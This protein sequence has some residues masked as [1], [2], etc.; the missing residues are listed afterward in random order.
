VVA[1]P[2][3]PRYRAAVLGE[4]ALP[5]SNLHEHQTKRRKRPSAGTYRS[6]TGRAAGTATQLS[7][8]L[9]PKVLITHHYD[10]VLGVE[11]LRNYLKKH[12]L[13]D[14]HGSDYLFHLILDAT[15]DHYAPLLDHFDDSLDAL[16]AQVLAQPAKQQLL[17]LLGIKRE[18]VAFRKTLIH[19]RE[20]L[21]RMA[22]GEFAL[23]SQREMAY[24]RNVYDHLV[25]FTELIDSSRDM[26]SD[27]MQTH[28]A[29]ISNRLNEVM[30]VLAMLSTIVLPMTLIAGI[31]GMNFE[32]MPELHWQL[33]YPVAIG[34][35]LTSAISSLVFFRWKKW[36]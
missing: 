12:P 16:E 1:N 9:A 23:I 5:E 11:E 2:L 30:K 29:A 3:A 13:R 21:A 33:G 20:V 26:V 32:E 24:Y 28:M 31:Y 27:L 19:E 35:M 34:L 25:R 15:V 22:R 18:I 17:D 4:P 8:V 10:P 7:A 14:E 36:I 6:L